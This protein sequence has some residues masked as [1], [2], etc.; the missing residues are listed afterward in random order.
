MSLTSYSP[1]S[2]S[3]ELSQLLS[4]F[5]SKSSSSGSLTGSGRAFALIRKGSGRAFALFYK[6]SSSPS[7]PLLCVSFSAST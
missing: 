6:S 7:S 1:F 4:S 2:P 3:K 5:A